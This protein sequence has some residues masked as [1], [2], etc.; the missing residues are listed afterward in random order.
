MALQ[1]AVIWYGGRW[2]LIA[3][4]VRYDRYASRE[5]AL[6]AAQRL[7]AQARRQGYEAEVLVQ[8]VGGELTQLAAPAERDPR[9]GDEPPHEPLNSPA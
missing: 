7:A 2:T 8:G 1:F 5:S 4:G 6:A 9:G 3:P